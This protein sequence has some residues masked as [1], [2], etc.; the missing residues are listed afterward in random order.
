[1]SKLPSVSV[2]GLDRLSLWLMAAAMVL[3]IG[4]NSHGGP[5]AGLAWHHLGWPLIACSLLLG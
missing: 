4:L 5:G 3:I 1:M 2:R